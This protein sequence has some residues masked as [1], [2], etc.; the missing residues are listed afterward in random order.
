M[1]AAPTPAEANPVLERQGAL[2]IPLRAEC[3]LGSPIRFLSRSG[4]SKSSVYNEIVNG[5]QYAS[6]EHGNKW[7]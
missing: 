2:T 6:N 3:R 1:A 5:T 4:D 7:Q